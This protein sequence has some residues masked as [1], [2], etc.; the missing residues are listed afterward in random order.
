MDTLIQL[1]ASWILPALFFWF[2]FSVLAMT[3]VERIQAYLKFRQKGLEEV[4]EKL[5]G[6]EL[7][8]D[9]YKHALVN[10]LEDARPSYISASLFA[11]VIMDWILPNVAVQTSDEKSDKS[12]VRESIQNSIKSLAKKNVE[13]SDVLLASVVQAS[14]KTEKVSEFLEAIQKDLEAWFL[15]AVNQM[16]PVYAARL[17]GLILWVG[18]VVALV[19]N[20]DVINM[21]ARLWETSKYAELLD[22]A[23]KTGQNV[24]IDT[25]LITM[26]PVGW[27][28]GYLPSTP[29]QWLLKV[30]G[31]YLGAFLIAFGSQYAYNL[32]K[33]QYQ[34]SE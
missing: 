13:F 9:F 4:I 19:S 26:L 20:F 2:L 17:Q 18:L 1:A 33:K 31:I 11:K 3:I 7:K 21:T 25:N 23:E 6:E 24:P 27:Y 28:S 15:E 12:A 22:L 10:P 8:E 32:S 16:S 14:M 30:A 34:P 5:V 29:A